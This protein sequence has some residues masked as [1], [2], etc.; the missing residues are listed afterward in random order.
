MGAMTSTPGTGPADSAPS[1][2]HVP[3]APPAPPTHS[4]RFGTALAVAVASGAIIAVQGKLNGELATRGAGAL[5]SSWFAYLGAL[6][7]AVVLLVVLGRF[8]SAVRALRHSRWWWFA[9]GLCS[10]PLV[11]SMAVGI[12]VVGVALASVCAV[13][14]QTVSGL[15]LDSRGVGLDAPLRLTVRRGVAGLGAVLGLVVAVLSSPGP[16]TGTVLAAVGTG[17][18]LFVGG[19]LLSVQSAGNGVVATRTGDVLVP[20]VASI[21]GGLVGLTVVC[22]IAAAVGGLSDVALPSVSSEWWVYLGGPMG[23]IITVSAAFAVRTLGTFA[24]T[25]SIVGGQLVMALVLDVVGGVGVGWA[26]LLS[27]VIIAGSVSLTVTRS[28]ARPTG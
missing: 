24:M 13:A 10:V 17:L 28:R 25:L 2:P 14:G 15:I 22:A 12:P 1:A 26:T 6:V 19:L 8:R 4:A 20:T 16:S 9:V 3:S 21:V 7:M 5:V 23:A 11:M 18:F 27:V